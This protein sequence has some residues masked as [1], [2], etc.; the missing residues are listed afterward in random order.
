[1]T[2]D[3]IN[4][5]AEFKKYHYDGDQE[6]MAELV[7]AGQ[8]PKYFIISCIDSRCNPGT[9][10]RAQPGIFF[11]HKA[12][13]AIVRPY[14]KGTALAAAL[15]FA[16]EYNNV[17]HV[18]VL[19][20]TKCG[21]VKAMAED[22]QDEEISS[23]INVAKHGLEKAKA[24]CSDHDEI[25][26]KTEQEVILESV[27]NLKA[28]PSVVKA[29]KENKITVKAWQFDITNGDLLEHNPNTNK[30]ETITADLP[31]KDSRASVGGTS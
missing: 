2:Q 6:L 27:E 3:L 1:M 25:L 21:A 7:E 28:Y 20:H 8:D 14:H 13:G 31:Q 24:C 19:G 26:A 30:F 5:A 22:I 17:K 23:F 12:M 9:I 10:F 11:A 15:Q 16:L 29:L 4:G 18:I